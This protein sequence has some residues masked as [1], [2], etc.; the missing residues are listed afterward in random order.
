MSSVGCS[1]MST[2]D[3]ITLNYGILG[4]IPS[5]EVFLP[6]FGI[7]HKLKQ[8][9]EFCKL[10]TKILTITNREE[11]TELNYFRTAEDKTIR[12]GTSCSNRTILTLPLY[13]LA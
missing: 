6:R 7:F 13:V 3:Q 2:F 10:V 1:I 9:F 12:Q 4:A 11:T 5:A 8:V